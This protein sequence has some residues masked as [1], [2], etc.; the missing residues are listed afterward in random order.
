MRITAGTSGLEVITE[1]PPAVKH[2]SGQTICDFGCC[3][4]LKTD[5]KIAVLLAE[6]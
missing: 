5:Q 2:A 4:S 3:R 1:R 6:N